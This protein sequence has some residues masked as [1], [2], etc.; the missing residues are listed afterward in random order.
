MLSFL[1]FLSTAIEPKVAK[2][3]RFCPLKNDKTTRNKG[4]KAKLPNRP[5]FTPPPPTGGGGFDQGVLSAGF[6]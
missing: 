1:Q 4:K 6:L 5:V 3:T 2:R